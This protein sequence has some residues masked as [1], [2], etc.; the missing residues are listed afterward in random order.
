MEMPE[1]VHTPIML[2]RPCVASGEALIDMERDKLSL[3][4]G[5]DKVEFELH[6]ALYIPSFG[7]TCYHVDVAEGWE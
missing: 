1:D 3:N 7:D 5:K 4:M 6:K 2:G